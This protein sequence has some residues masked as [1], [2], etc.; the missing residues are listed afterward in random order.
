[1]GRASTLPKRF[2][3]MF[4]TLSDGTFDD[5]GWILED[6]YDGF[7]MVAKIESDCQ[8]RGRNGVRPGWLA[9]RSFTIGEHT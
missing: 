8:R 4:A 9:C 2:Q 1:M 7:R 3:P 5:P 6:K